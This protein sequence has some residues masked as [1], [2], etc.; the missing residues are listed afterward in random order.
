MK[1]S[2][3]YVGGLLSIALSVYAIFLGIVFPVIFKRDITSYFLEREM[4][5][6]NDSS[7]NNG[8]K[9]NDLK[10]RKTIMKDFLN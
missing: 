3:S 9:K 2:L 1:N 7:S 10:E 8:N 4:K 5:K 6:E